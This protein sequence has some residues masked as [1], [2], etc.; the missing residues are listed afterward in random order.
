MPRNVKKVMTLP[1][2][3]IFSHLQKKTRVKIWLYEDTKLQIEGQI[4]GFDEYM[5]MTLEDA[6][7]IQNSKRTEVG[8]ILLKGDS[9]TL[10]QAA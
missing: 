7:E 6:V 3:V 9:I 2:N 8:R 4:I 1:I 10:L 5:N